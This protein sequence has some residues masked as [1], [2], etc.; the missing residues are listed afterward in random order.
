MRRETPIHRKLIDVL[1][2]ALAVGCVVLALI[3][4]GWILYAAAS[5]GL[6]PLLTPGFLTNRF[7]LACTA[8]DCSYGGIGPALQGT[9]ILVGLASLIALPVGILGG[10]FL[11][12]MGRNRFGRTISFFA[13]VMSGTPSIVVGLFTYTL[14][15]RYA[16]KDAYTVIAG[17][18]ALSILMLPVVIR[19]TEES[20]RLVPR[21]VREAALALGVPRYRTILRIVLP[22]AGGA[23]V[24]G[25]LLA[26]ARSAGEAAPLLFTA[27]GLQTIFFYQGLNQPISAVP[28]YIYYWSQQPYSN[29]KADAWGLAF[30]I[31]LLMLALS[32]T[33]RFVLARRAS[34][35]GGTT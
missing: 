2:R 9:A 25:G 27:F 24:T 20:L 5:R 18:I 7:P 6:P 33:A 22:T 3:P 14:F 35:L 13:D 21:S 17:T 30:V 1:L 29:L 8:L 12:E 26:V 11:S 4:L 31:I 32:L 16:P 15:L 28:P 10:I 34:L 19:T 23:V